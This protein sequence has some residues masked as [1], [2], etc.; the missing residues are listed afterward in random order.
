MAKKRDERQCDICDKLIWPGDGRII[1]GVKV[2]TKC[3]VRAKN[4]I[5]SEIED[6][7]ILIA[8]E[9]DDTDCQGG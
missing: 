3:Q 8:L 9:D 1:L 6:T 2:Y 7:D 5:M 4:K